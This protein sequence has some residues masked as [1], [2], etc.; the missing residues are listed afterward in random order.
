VRVP[1]ILL[2]FIGIVP[3]I[4][5]FD[6]DFFLRI[7]Y[8]IIEVG[9]SIKTYQGEAGNEKNGYYYVVVERRSPRK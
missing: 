4:L 3:S 5:L 2:L 8:I 9:Y 6:F 7:I 1:S